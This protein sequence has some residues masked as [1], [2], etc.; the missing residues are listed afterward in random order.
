MLTTKE[1]L[2]QGPVW[3]EYQFTKKLNRFLSKPCLSKF[4]LETIDLTQ[5][6]N[7]KENTNYQISSK[8]KERLE[9]IT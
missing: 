8:I 4:K 6:K 7:F 3:W 2:N 5:I 1:K 9:E